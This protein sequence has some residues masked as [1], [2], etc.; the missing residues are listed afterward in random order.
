MGKKSD[1]AE[2][3]SQAATDSEAHLAQAEQDVYGDDPNKERGI[4]SRYQNASAAAK[5]H[6][7]IAESLAVAEQMIAL[8]NQLL[9]TAK[10]LHAAH[11]TAVEHAAAAKNEPPPV[12]QPVPPPAAA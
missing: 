7:H 9:D 5:A 10:R 11:K 1:A 4:G 3:K 12:P 8:A 6:L 2:A